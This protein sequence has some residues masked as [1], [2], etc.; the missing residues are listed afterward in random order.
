MNYYSFKQYD[1]ALK[2]FNESLRINKSI[3][4]QSNSVAN[5]L[6]EIGTVYYFKNELKKVMECYE[7]SLSI[8]KRRYGDKHIELTDTIHNIAIILKNQ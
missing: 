7:E 1:D 4:E 2:S 8:K 5:T 6:K 3:D